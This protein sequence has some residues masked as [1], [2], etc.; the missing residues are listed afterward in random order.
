MKKIFILSLILLCTGCIRIDKAENRD[1][2]IDNIVSTQSKPNT[3]ALGYKYYLPL[4]VPI[5]YDNNYNQ[6]LKYATEQN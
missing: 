6:Q 5:V 4:G 1:A 2:V 3:M